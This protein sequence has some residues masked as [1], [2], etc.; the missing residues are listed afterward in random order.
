MVYSCH[1]VVDNDARVLSGWKLVRCLHTVEVLA[2]LDCVS[3]FLETRSLSS[4]HSSAVGYFSQPSLRR[5]LLNEL[6]DDDDDL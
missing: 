6:D 4:L 1:S 3:L 5:F 2:L